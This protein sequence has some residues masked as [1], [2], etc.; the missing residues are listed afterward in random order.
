MMTDTITSQNIDLPP[1][2]PCINIKELQG[3]EPAI[4]QTNYAGRNL[5]L[6]WPNYHDAMQKEVVKTCSLL[7]NSLNAAS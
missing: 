1:E 3:F 7:P 2:S 5:I 6:I 4:Y